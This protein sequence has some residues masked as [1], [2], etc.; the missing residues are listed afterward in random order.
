MEMETPA[1]K[2]FRLF[3]KTLTGT[4][5]LRDQ[6]SD[7]LVHLAEEVAAEASRLEREAVSHSA[8]VDA[9]EF[10]ERDL[11][12]RWY[13]KLRDVNTKHEES[14][15]YDADIYYEE[16]TDH[17]RLAEE[18]R[19]KLGDTHGRLKASIIERHMTFKRQRKEAKEAL[20]IE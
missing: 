4:D 16:M 8:T 19:E 18:A 14:A 3:V 15:E 6:D 5:M 7:L 2:T 13:E 20:Y 9:M 1:L 12:R 11:Y 17:F 10:E